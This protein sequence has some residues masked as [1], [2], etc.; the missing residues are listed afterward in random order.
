MERHHFS[1][2]LTGL[3][4]GFGLLLS[5]LSNPAKI[6]GFLDIAGSWDPSLMLVMGGA[7]AVGI[8][9]FTLAKKRDVS[10]IGQPMRLPKHDV[11]EKRVI[12]GSLG[13]GVGWGLAGLCPGPSLV[14]LGTGTPKAMVFVAAMLVGMT[15]FEIIDRRKQA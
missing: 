1:A 11:I 12:L 14:A 9:A 2:L 5:G 4:F 6:L 3:L 13:F 7:V 8:I 15:V 10:L